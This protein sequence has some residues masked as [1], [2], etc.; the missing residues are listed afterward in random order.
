METK[1]RFLL[2]AS[3]IRALAETWALGALSL[4][5]LLSNYQRIDDRLLGQTFF[6]LMPLLAFWYSIRLRVPDSI[7]LRVPDSIRLRVPAYAKRTSVWHLVWYE[8]R[9]AL[10]LSPLTSGTWLILLRVTGLYAPLSQTILGPVGGILVLA[11]L[12]LFVPFFRAGIHV[13][14]FWLRLQRRRLVWA[15]THIQL[16]FVVVLV[17]LVGIAMAMGL[18]LQRGPLLDLDTWVFTILPF[19]GIAGVASLL[20]LVAILPPALFFAWLAARRTNQRLDTL[21]QATAALRRGDYATRIP[22]EG[23]DEI[24]QL[25]G[26]FNAMAASLER[27]REEL[28]SERDKVAA[29]LDARRELVAGV[30]HELRTPLAT[31]RGYLESLQ[32]LTEAQAHTPE[33]TIR[34]DLA[35]ME[36]ELTRLQTLIDDLFTLSRAEVGGLTMDIKLLDVREVIER[37]VAAAAPLAWQ[38]NRVQVVA[39][40]PEETLSAKADRDR[41]EQILVNLL[42][43]AIRHTPPGGIVAVSARPSGEEVQMR[44]CDTGEGIPTEDLPHIW[45]RFYRGRQ[46]QEH[47]AQGAGLGLALVKELTEAMGGRVDV[48]SELNDGSCFFV[49]LP[50]EEGSHER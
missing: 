1:R 9:A 13:W 30:S 39:D 26:D 43:N 42:R 29:L 19:A 45:E 47:D 36:Q 25:Q 5:A 15:L 40:I 7:R 33:T 35:V 46:A 16:Q 23:Q 20:G 21:T 37:R 27:A 6:F 12:G 10:A 48:Q 3:L 14:L 2:G 31:V 8:A 22:V 44:V 41:L 38:R 50:A 28:R 4:W 18:A 17:A 11:T 49:Y 32:Q 24:A 34:R